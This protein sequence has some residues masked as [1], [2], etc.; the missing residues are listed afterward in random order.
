M[1]LVVGLGNPGEQYART[2]HNVG[3]MVADMLAKS[4]FV[5]RWQSKFDGL[6]AEAVVK[7]EKVLIQKPGTYMNLS[8]NAVRKAFDFYKL[9]PEQILVVCDDLDLPIGKM[10]LR[11]SGSSG[12]QRGLRH[13]CQVLGTDVVSRLRIGIGRPRRASEQNREG[14]VDYVLAEFGAGEK[15]VVEETLIDACRAVERWC[16]SGIG[17][18]MNEFNGKEPAKE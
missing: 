3:F 8:G 5:D 6:I 9:T 14:T 17:V 11:R 13:V 15:Q 18:A 4:N 16:E 1:K 10:R 7:G 12:G 2:R